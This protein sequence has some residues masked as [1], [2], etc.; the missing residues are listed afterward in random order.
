MIT[1]HDRN[2]DSNDTNYD[3]SNDRNDSDSSNRYST[4][5]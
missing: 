3:E 1:S 5:R 2:S 4:S